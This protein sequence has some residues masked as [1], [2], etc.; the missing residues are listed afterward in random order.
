MKFRG[1]I[2]GALLGFLQ[3]AAWVIMEYHNS[4]KINLLNIIGITGY[5]LMGFW[6]GKKFDKLK[7]LSEKDALTGLYNRHFVDVIFPKLLAQVKRN[8]MKLSL[9]ML[10]CN[11]FKIIND[12]YGHKK[13]DLVIKNISNLL[14]NSTRDSDVVARWG[15]D[16]FLIISPF[17][18]LQGTK[19]VIKRIEQ[20]LLEMSKEMGID[21]SVSIG[22]AVYPNEADNIDDLIKIADKNMYDT[23]SIS[24]QSE[25]TKISHVL[26]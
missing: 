10:D 8:N 22:I 16:E 5:T 17:T 1:R 21:I 25:P 18:D 3:A 4:G 23:K 11:N 26:N 6:I 24:K 20:S 14:L 19:V 12:T 9:S 13:G 2:M 7:Y 15:G